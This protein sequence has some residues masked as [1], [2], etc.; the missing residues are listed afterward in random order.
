MLALH[1]GIALNPNPCAVSSARGCAGAC[2]KSGSGHRLLTAAI[3]SQIAPKV[4]RQSVH[5]RRQAILSN[6]VLPTRCLPA[7]QVLEIDHLEQ[8]GGF[9]DVG[10]PTFES[11]NSQLLN[12]AS[13]PRN[14]SGIGCKA[15]FD[16][17]L[18]GKP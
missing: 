8:V 1:H 16:A 10:S 2:V 6:P 4:L 3:A 5:V 15:L 17:G 12:G 7:P 11:L 14:G 9:L 13:K 18:P